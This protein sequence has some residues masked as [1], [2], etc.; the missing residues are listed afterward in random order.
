MLC[1]DLLLIVAPCCADKIHCWCVIQDGTDSSGENK[2]R[3]FQ[4]RC[5]SWPRRRGS[6]YEAAAQEAPELMPVRSSPQISAIPCRR[7]RFCQRQLWSTGLCVIV[8][9]Q[10]S[11]L[12]M[13]LVLSS[14]SDLGLYNLHA[15]DPEIVCCIIILDQECV[16]ILFDVWVNLSKQ[17]MVLQRKFTAKHVCLL[18][19]QAYQNRSS[20]C[21]FAR[22]PLDKATRIKH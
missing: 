10:G 8:P 21:K 22:L 16:E 11:H 12:E 6:D 9:E 14:Q 13:S 20:G 2:R 4:D 17:P 18:G 19:Q 3:P 15:C 5:D 7:H 1:E